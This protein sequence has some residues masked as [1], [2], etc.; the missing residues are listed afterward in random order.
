MLHS[1]T[2]RCWRLRLPHATKITEGG[3]DREPAL[4]LVG[5]AEVV[6]QTS[7]DWTDVAL[8]VATVM[9]AESINVNSKPPSKQSNTD[10]RRSPEGVEPC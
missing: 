5:R 1:P 10:R 8:S 4:E 9:T 6:Q 3:G 2:S 7:E